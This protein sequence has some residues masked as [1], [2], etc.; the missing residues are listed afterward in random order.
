MLPELLAA[1][2]VSDKAETYASIADHPYPLREQYLIASSELASYV[3][4][5]PLSSSDLAQ[6]MKSRHV[7]PA[8]KREIADDAD[9]VADRLSKL[10]VSA[11]CEWAAKGNDVSTQLLLALSREGAPADDILGLLEPHL[12]DIEPSTLDDILRALGDEYE[13]LTRLG[14]HHPRLK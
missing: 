4:E 9:Y 6:V 12:P 10:S 14:R 11:M 2:E 1:G 5:L 3:T 8:V 7:P 13:P